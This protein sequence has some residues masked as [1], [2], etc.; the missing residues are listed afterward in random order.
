MRR[1]TIRTEVADPE[2]VAAAV[3]PD[4]TT[5]METTTERAASASGGERADRP[6]SDVVTTV[7]RESTGGLR[8]TVDDYV[9]N[10]RVAVQVAETASGHT[11]N[12]E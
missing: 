12:H 11:N 3:R 6:A 4:N 7:E 8:S 1:A 10:L 9:V 5:E 2:R